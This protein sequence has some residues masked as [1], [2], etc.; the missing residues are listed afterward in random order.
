MH[1]NTPIICDKSIS[2]LDYRNMVRIEIDGTISESVLPH[3]FTF[4][5]EYEDRANN[6]P[7]LDQ[8]QTMESNIL[9][10]YSTNESGIPKNCTVKQN[11]GEPITF[12]LASKAG[13][14]VA[15]TV[16]QAKVLWNGKWQT[17]ETQCQVT[18][19]E[20]NIHQHAISITLKLN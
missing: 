11:T 8:F 7:E 3:L 14:H 6:I 10:F 18:L 12:F 19:K 2:Y 16:L 1:Y 15:D 5:W 4:P 9:S 20:M 13:D 17:Y